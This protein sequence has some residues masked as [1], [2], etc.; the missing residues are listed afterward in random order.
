MKIPITVEFD[1]EIDGEAKTPLDTEE[2]SRLIFENVI[3]ESGR[4]I[5]PSEM[6][7]DTDDYAIIIKSIE[8]KLEE[9]D[10]AL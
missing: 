7:D 2:I 8:R 3:C 6:I 10:N 9:N 5:I 1:V 4:S